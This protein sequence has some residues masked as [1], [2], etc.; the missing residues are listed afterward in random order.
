M[1]PFYEIR[2]DLLDQL[3][4]AKSALDEYREEIDRAPNAD[5]SMTVSN[6]SQRLQ[7]AV[8]AVQDTLQDVEEAVLRLSQNPQKFG[9]TLKELEERKRFLKEA[10]AEARS[11]QL[12]LSKPYP[13]RAPRATIEASIADETNRLNAAGN[14]GPDHESQMLQQYQ[15]QLINDQDEALDSVSYTIGT[16]RQQ[17]ELMGRELHDHSE[18]LEDLD[19]QTDGTSNRLQRGMTRLNTFIRENQDDKSCWCIMI[20]IFVLFVLLIVVIAI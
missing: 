4:T 8:D 11:I 5:H 17:A 7:S 13:L 19:L 1:D 18:L 20:L 3:D 2:D 6:A 9:I 16:L 10:Q 12:E 15:K 14:T